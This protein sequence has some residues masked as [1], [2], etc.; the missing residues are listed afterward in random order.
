MLVS[1]PLRSA[2][3]CFASLSQSKI[4]TRFAKS[5]PC[6]GPSFTPM[7]QD[8]RG[9]WTRCSTRP[10]LPLQTCETV[11]QA[12][13]LRDVDWTFG[14]FLLFSQQHISV[15]TPTN[16]L[17]AKFLGETRLIPL[18]F[19][20]LKHY[21]I[22][23]TRRLAAGVDRIRKLPY[24]KDN[25]RARRRRKRAETLRKGNDLRC[26]WKSSACSPTPKRSKHSTP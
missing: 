24:N 7:D 4:A 12:N 25:S 9:P 5:S 3:G 15:P 16:S 14:K 18:D 19:L 20:A 22:D 13:G 11:R 17:P 1:L 6:M 8:P 23:N 26:L 2:Q 21:N 10:C